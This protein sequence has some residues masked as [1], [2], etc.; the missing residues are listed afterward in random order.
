MC[1]ENISF[2]M[3]DKVI[4]ELRRIN[5]QKTYKLNI[6]SFIVYDKYATLRKRAILCIY[7]SSPLLV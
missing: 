2:V 7:N 3:Y 4:E 1:R 6:T 5:K